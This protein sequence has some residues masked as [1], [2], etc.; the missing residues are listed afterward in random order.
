[1]PEAQLFDIID[2][3]GEVAK[4]SGATRSQVALA[5]LLQ[6]PTV[7]TLLVGA[8]SEEQFTESLDAIELRLSGDQLVRLDGVSARPAGYPHALQHG[9]GAERMAPPAPAGNMRVDRAFPIPRG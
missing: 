9:V 2:C 4:E 7:S 8:G 1:M 3:L 5:W 6:R